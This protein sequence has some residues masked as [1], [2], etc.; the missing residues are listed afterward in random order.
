[1]S[2]VD[3]PTDPQVVSGEAVPPDEHTLRVRARQKQRSEASKL[4][5]HD[6]PPPAEPPQRSST[7]MAEVSRRHR[8]RERDRRAERRAMQ[9]VVLLFLGLGGGAFALVNLMLEDPPPSGPVEVAEVAETPP[10][11]PTGVISTQIDE[12]PD[13]PA[14]QNLVDVG[15]TIAA[16]G[17]PQ[18]DATEE[19][20]GMGALAALETCRFAYAVWEFSP[21]KRFRFMTTC[22]ALDGQ[23][24]FG[25][26]V[27]DGA[28]IRMSPLITDT[29]AVVSEFHI[30]RPSKMVSHVSRTRDGPVVLEISQKVTAIRPGLDGDSW[31]DAFSAK[32]TIHLPGERTKAP[33]PSAPSPPPP[34]KQAEGD[35]LLELLKKG[36]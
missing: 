7:E 36:K 9:L 17:I 31:R 10:P 28:V 12:T 19:G 21:N 23:V 3:D 11:P 34:P 6:D 26:Y 15:L 27:I 18:V 8:K 20:A 2:G 35:P 33:P 1:M 22:S 5:V 30:A 25:A 32:N 13:I 14:L 24:M 16:E 4:V 29:D